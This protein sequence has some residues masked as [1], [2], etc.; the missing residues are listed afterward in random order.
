[1]AA[2]RRGW[3]RAPDVDA[4]EQEQPDDVDEVPVPGRRLEA[5][6][7]PRREGTA[8]R[9]NRQ[10]S[11]KIVPMSTCAPWKPVAMKNVEP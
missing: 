3:A 1:M 9:A 5:E 6:V 2:G 4:G 7:R 10:T 8:D 11:R